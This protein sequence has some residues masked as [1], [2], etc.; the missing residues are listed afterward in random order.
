MPGELTPPHEPSAA[1]IFMATLGHLD[2]TLG[3]CTNVHSG[4]SWPEVL[5]NLKK[6][7][8]SV[9]DWLSPLFP[10][11]SFGVGIWLSADS[12]QEL[13]QTQVLCNFKSFLKEHDLKVLSINGFP[14]GNFHNDEVKFQVYQPDWTQEERLH[15]TLNLI[16]VAQ[17]IGSPG[18]NFPISTLPISFQNWISQPEQLKQVVSHFLRVISECVLIEK[19]YGAQISLCLE[20]EPLCYL[21]RGKDVVDFYKE[22]LLPLGTQILK[23]QF[24]LNSDAAEECILKTIQV[25]YDTCHAAVCFEEPHD[26]LKLYQNFGIKIGKIQLSSAPRLQLFNGKTAEGESPENLLENL[27][28]QRY[29]H[30][31]VG[32][33]SDGQ[34]MQ[35]DDLHLAM[36]DWKNLKL[37]GDF[38]IHYHIPIHQKKFHSLE[39][40]Q[41]HILELLR[42]TEA[43][44][45]CHFYEVE[46]YT[47]E[48]ILLNENSSEAH[49]TKKLA[50]ELNWAFDQMMDCSPS[51]KGAERTEAYE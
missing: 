14:Y 36:E 50:T 10:K 21:Q 22:Y 16:Q 26:L 2:F 34:K 35:W 20:P 46:T 15:Y 27:R 1:R 25:C 43:S 19:N 24:D 48:R 17:E 23:D 28:D 44:S 32:R 40:T 12:A 11:Q 9:R 4:N 6:Y 49:L 3:Y 31:V 51:K 33:R 29:L 38:R 7:S 37:S 39:T 8:L 41:N 13:R 30:Q 47:W 5:E 42:L 18:V 45:L